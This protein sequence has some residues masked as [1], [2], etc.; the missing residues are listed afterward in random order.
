MDFE[1]AEGKCSPYRECRRQK[2]PGNDA[3]SLKRTDIGHEH[4]VSNFDLAL[5][6]KKN[7]PLRYP[8]PE[9]LFLNKKVNN[10]ELLSTKLT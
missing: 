3:Q 5:L 6:E 9:Q 1:E 8:S 2:I 10:R 7:Y 4:P